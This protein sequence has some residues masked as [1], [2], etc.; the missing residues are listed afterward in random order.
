MYT[1]VRRFQ[2]RDGRV[3]ESGDVYPQPDA[4]KPTNARLKT[5]S[6][7]KNRYEQIFIKKLSPSKG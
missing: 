7:T 5:L 6:T 1:V 3:Y 2:D 4:E